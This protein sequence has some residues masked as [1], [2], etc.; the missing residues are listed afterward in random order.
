MDELKPCPFCGG[1]AEIIKIKVSFHDE[2]NQYDGIAIRA[3]CKTCKTTS[4]YKRS[5]IHGWFKIG[6]KEKAIEAWNRRYGN[7]K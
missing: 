4:P 3:E 2:N 7:D 1:E 5:K 6:E